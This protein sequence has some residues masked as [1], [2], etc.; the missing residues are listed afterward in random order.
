MT[1]LIIL[2]LL[3][4]LLLIICTIGEIINT[5]N[6]VLGRYSDCESA[7]EAAKLSNCLC[8]GIKCKDGSLIAAIPRKLKNDIYKYDD[9]S[10]NNNNKLNN[11]GISRWTEEERKYLYKIDE[12][13]GAAIVGIPSDTM[14]IV[15]L[16]REE[17]LEYKSKIG[18]PIPISLLADTISNYLYN[19]IS[20]GDTRPLAIDM[21]LISGDDYYTNNNDNDMIDSNIIKIENTGS[22][23]ETDLCITKTLLDDYNHDTSNIINQ[24]YQEL[25][26]INSIKNW[27]ELTCEEVSTEIENFTKKFF[28]NE[29]IKPQISFISKWKYLQK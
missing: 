6:N 29:D 8:I 2:I 12:C 25:Q 26:K 18:L 17:S 21:I 22:Y 7:L 15:Q 24:C 27:K 3:L 10:N 1:I 11:I 5:N 16:L 13:I 19:L 14:H 20:A 4:L 9:N 28:K 23:H